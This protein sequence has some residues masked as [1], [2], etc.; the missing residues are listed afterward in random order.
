MV[1]I[2]Y[3]DYLD[4]ET[5]LKKFIVIEVFLI[6]YINIKNK[7]LKI[8]TSLHKDAAI[9]VFFILSLKLNIKHFEEYGEKVCCILII[10]KQ[11]T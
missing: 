8:K 6:F 11:K 3:G 7:I 9:F 1:K 2:S 4:E 10:Y 5:L